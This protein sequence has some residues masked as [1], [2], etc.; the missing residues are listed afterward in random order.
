MLYPVERQSGYNPGMVAAV[1]QIVKVESDGRIEIVSPEFRAGTVME[2]I[3]LLAPE[4]TLATPAERVAAL[5]RLRKSIGL[6]AKA[7]DECGRARSVPSAM[8]GARPLCHDS[9]RHE[10]SDSLTG[11]WNSSGGAS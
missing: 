3:V 4:S 5:A 10:L 1:R 2:V 11:A 9:P 7:A 6:T 8:P